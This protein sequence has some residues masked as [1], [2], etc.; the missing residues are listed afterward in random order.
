[1]TPQSHA[2]PGDRDV[3]G[4][5][6]FD[7][8]GVVYLGPSTI[9]GAPEAVATLSGIGWQIL[10][11]TNNSAAT[12]DSVARQLGERI[13]LLI[14]P[15]TIMTSAMATATYL[16]GQRLTSA[17]IVGSQQLEDTIRASGISIVGPERA[18]AVVVGRDRSL[19]QATI[20][21]A[22][23]AI[24]EGARFVVT[25]TDATFP[26]PY[27]PVAGAGETV[28]AIAA[29]SGKPFVVCGKPHRPMV[30]LVAAQ[31]NSDN[32]WMIGD[33]LETDIAFAKQANWTSVLTLSGVTQSGTE[34]P[35][36]LVPDFVID[37]IADLPILLDKA[38]RSP[39]DEG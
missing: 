2:D 22:C 19:N 32:V 18:A 39:L 14:D 38:T 35:E 28:D 13:S 27:G 33:R 6:V 17:L 16:V 36:G 3:P 21:R 37:S 23:L 34:F 30:A 12:P 10:F 9:T 25:N 7:L 26:T 5:V 29:A 4:T 31:V 20:D 11:A 8:D 15:A 24:S 1:M